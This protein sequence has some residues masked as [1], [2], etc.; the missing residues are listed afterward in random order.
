MTPALRIVQ[1]N[2][3][4][5]R[6][7]W[8]GSIFFSFLQPTLFL[9]AMGVTLGALVDPGAMLFPAGIDFLE[10]LAP[11]LLAAACMQTASF[12]SSFPI[13]SKM[14]WQ[15]NYEAIGATPMGIRDIVLGEL[16][17][18]AARLFMVAAAFTVVITLFGVP[19]S[20]LALLAVPA[21]VLT[22]L[23]FSAPIMAYAATVRKGGSFNGLFR[24]IITPLFLFSGVFF[25]VT[26]LPDALEP[27]PWLT[28]LFHGVELVR[29]LTLGTLAGPVWLVHAGYL[30]GLLALG[31]RIAIGAFRRKLAA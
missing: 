2:A 15:R 24:F 16:A 19:R 28:P 20:P 12:E 31:T 7:V 8:R 30:A 18:M 3:L 13:T 11:G 5:Y 10:F 22:G 9:L 14:T 26:R 23:A 4:V 1:R 6:R 17:W 25:P 21:A 29:G 27:V